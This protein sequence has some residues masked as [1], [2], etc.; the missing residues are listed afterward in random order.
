MKRI[1]CWAILISTCLG[2]QNQVNSKEKEDQLI[3]ATQNEVLRKYFRPTCF[4]N[5]VSNTT[6]GFANRQIDIPATGGTNSVFAEQCVDKQINR[7]VT[8][9]YSKLEKIKTEFGELEITRDECLENS[10]TK[11]LKDH[12]K[13]LK[14]KSNEQDP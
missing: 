11:A 6:H 9:I 1:V 14:N 2:F 3:P 13:E 10:D 5:G 8:D 12:F 4:H 7:F